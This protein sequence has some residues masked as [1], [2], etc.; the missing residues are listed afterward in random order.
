MPG[1]IAPV[2]Y[3]VLLV[4]YYRS[5]DVPIGYIIL[6]NI[7]HTNRNC[8]LGIVIGEMESQGKGF[9]NEVIGMA[10]SYAFDTLNLNRITQEVVENNEN[11]LKLYRKLGFIEEDRLKKHYFVEGKYFDVIVLSIFKH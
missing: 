9:G 8:T 11:A 3:F 2:W 6:N 4:F 10:I 7:N 5:N 1:I